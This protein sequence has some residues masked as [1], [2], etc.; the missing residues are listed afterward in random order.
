MKPSEPD[1]LFLWP[2]PAA[3]PELAAQNR[4]RLQRPDGP[5]RLATSHQPVLFHA[6]IW[7]R[8]FVLEQVA[9]SW[10]WE[11]VYFEADSDEC[12]VSADVPRSDPLRVERV[13]LA[14]GILEHLPAPDRAAWNEFCQRLRSGLPGG[15]DLRC[16][17]Q[18]QANLARF[19]ACLRWRAGGLQ[20]LERGWQ[21][22][23]LQ[24]PLAARL[25]EPIL[26]DPEGFR[27]CFNRALTQERA[28]RRLRSRAHPFPD[29]RV[30][31]G[32]VELP[33][34]V[35]RRPL[36][37]ELATDRLWTDRPLVAAG[38]WRELPLRPRAMLWTAFCR[39]SCD[40]YLHGT[41]GASYDRATDH[42]LKSFYR[43]EPPGYAVAWLNYR[44]A[45]PADEEAPARLVRATQELRSLR[46]NP[47]RSLPAHPLAAEKL[48][49][50]TA[51]QSAPR[52]KRAELTRA[53]QQT[54]RQL[55]AQLAPLRLRLEAERAAARLACDELAAARYRGYSWLL[56]DPE[57][58]RAISSLSRPCRS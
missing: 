20:V 12:E 19:L 21:S 26:A 7:V 41:G 34:W 15:L 43:L 4:K 40:L 14:R 42:V 31:Q 35:E 48:H 23:W 56:V 6:G 58:L 52:G 2:E 33:L 8:E 47:Q 57:K 1:R 39:L 11:S 44:L 5:W 24:S 45:L 18:E 50:V 10:G 29:L 27:A 17:W 13:S 22:R 30:I 25:V 3:W 54:N 37:Y 49:L 16:D 38:Q 46:H 55:E 36:F 51:L 9:T 28:E 32:R 53:I